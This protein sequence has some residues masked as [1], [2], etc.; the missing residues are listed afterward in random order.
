MQVLPS[1]LTIGTDRIEVCEWRSDS[2]QTDVPILLLHDSLGCVALWRDFPMQLAEHTQRRVIAWDRTGFGK[3]SPRTQRPGLD[4]IR[5]EGQSMPALWDALGLPQVALLG[6]SVGGG[7]AIE[8]AAQH[9]DRV[10][11]V[12]TVAAQAF[13]E[14]RTLDG[15]RAAQQ[16]FAD[17][18]QRARL[19]RY[20]G[21][22][23]DWVLD[24][25]IGVWL[26]PAFASWSL[27]EA[28]AQVRCPLLAIHGGKDEYGSDE[29]PRRLTSLAGGPS[30]MRMLEGVGHAP[31]REQTPTVLS[32]IAEFLASCDA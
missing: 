30:T 20:H 7:M 3:S 17:P 27:D 10:A 13:A 6:H 4:F 11:A 19:A 21:E 24:A 29:H 12:I 18:A 9:P 25:W 26:D 23:T 28:L 15:I 5:E 2:L 8:A 16:Q 14:P 22:R 32:A 31:H 1:S